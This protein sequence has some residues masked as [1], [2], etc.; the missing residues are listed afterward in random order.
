MQIWCGHWRHIQP[1]LDMLSDLFLKSGI[2]WWTV[3]LPG[4]ESWAQPSKPWF[5]PFY[6]LLLRSCFM[7]KYLSSYSRGVNTNIIFNL[8]TLSMLNYTPR[9]QFREHKIQRCWGACPAKCLSRVS[10]SQ[11]SSVSLPTILPL[12]VETILNL[13]PSQLLSLELS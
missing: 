1:G 9:L 8:T 5:P 13:V 10:H 3:C 6:F 12:S 4:V 11:I 2:G 7:M